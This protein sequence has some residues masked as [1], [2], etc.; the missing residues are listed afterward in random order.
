MWTSSGQSSDVLEEQDGV[1]LGVSYPLPSAYIA[2][3]HLS[4]S[5]EHFQL[6]AADVIK[7]AW[8]DSL[9]LCPLC[10]YVASGAPPPTL[11]VYYLN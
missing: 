9:Y 8:L 7:W 5:N 11:L 4:T 10:G 1:V 3:G 6:L 2:S